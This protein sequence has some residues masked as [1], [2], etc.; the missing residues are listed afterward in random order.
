MAANAILARVFTTDSGEDPVSDCAH[1]QLDSDSIK[2]SPAGAAGTTELS[3]A[4]ADGGGRR[5]KPVA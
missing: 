5:A 3:C 4:V 1:D 2:E